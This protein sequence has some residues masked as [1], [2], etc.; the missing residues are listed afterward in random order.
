MIFSQ[1]RGNRDG[2]FEAFLLL[3][4]SLEKDLTAVPGEMLEWTSEI[5][6]W[7]AA[8]RVNHSE[9][10]IPTGTQSIRDHI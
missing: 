5:K 7:L 1:G 8:V 4:G 6:R 3:N 2:L 10:T 9:L